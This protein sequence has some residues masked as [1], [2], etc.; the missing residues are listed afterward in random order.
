MSCPAFVMAPYALQIR[1]KTVKAILIPDGVTLRSWVW[2]RVPLHGDVQRAHSVD[3][4]DTDV[5]LDAGRTGGSATSDLTRR[6]FRVDRF[7]L[8]EPN[9]LRHSYTIV[10][11]QQ[12]D[13]G[14]NVHPLNSQINT[15][16]PDIAVP[17]RGNV[18]VFRHGK[19]AKTQL[20]NVED[21]NWDAIEIILTTPRSKKAVMHH[22]WLAQDVMLYMLRFLSLIQ[23]MQFGH[24]NQ[25]CKAYTQLYT[26]GRIT[27][28]TSPF[29]ATSSFSP[30][31][32]YTPRLFVRFFQV[33]EETKSWIVGSVALAA[34]SVLSD[35][36]CPSNL[37]IITYNVHYSTWKR[38]LLSE[39]GFKTVKMYWA[40]GPY[41]HHAAVVM[42]V[43]HPLIPGYKISI[44]TSTTPS[45]TSLFFASPNTDQLV[46]ISAHEL[47]T[48]VLGNVSAQQHLMGWRPYLR[49]NPELP[50]VSLQLYRSWSQFPNAISLDMF[51]DH[52]DRPCGLS[53]PGVQRHTYGLEGFA[54][55]KWSG[56]DNQ[57]K[58]TDPTLL[59]MGKTR[60]NFRFG[61]RCDNSCCPNSDSYVEPPQVES[62]DGDEGSSYESN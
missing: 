25:R 51:T 7:P 40:S 13:T 1:S 9:D 16:V 28:Y 22:F 57:D 21:R 5:W 62:D 35:V 53:C 56:V 2:A 29:F 50:A 54:H 61:V 58:R 20:I 55:L 59:M 60:L 23:V 12:Y 44:A 46:A 42:V 10:V 43:E 34:A 24:I 31:S 19:T 14:P 30:P 33:L 38:F 17:W 52:W 37:N 41:L 27:R 18:L 6:S 8:D 15:M 11:T 26:K 47:I 49:R 45:M 39:S 3:E 4:V 48:P 32:S 36:P